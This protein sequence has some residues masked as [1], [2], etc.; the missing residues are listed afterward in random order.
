LAPPTK[1]ISASPVLKLWQAK[2]NAVRLEEHAVSTV[3]DGPL[4]L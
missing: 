1:L 3:R 4:R 2:W